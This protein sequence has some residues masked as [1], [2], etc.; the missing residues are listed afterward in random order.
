MKTLARVPRLDG[1]TDEEP[2]NVI[3]RIVEAGIGSVSESGGTAPRQEG[4]DAVHLGSEQA[5]HAMRVLRAD[6]GSE[7]DMFVSVDCPRITEGK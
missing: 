7:L 2:P 5:I 6:R 3:P 4:E 1:R